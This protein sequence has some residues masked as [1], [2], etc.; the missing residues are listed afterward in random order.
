MLKLSL[1]INAECQVPSTAFEVEYIPNDGKGG[2]KEKKKI[3]KLAHTHTHTHEKSHSL[4]VEHVQ[5]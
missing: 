3:R 4:D 2:N 5:H 1:M